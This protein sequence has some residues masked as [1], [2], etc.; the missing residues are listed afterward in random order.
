MEELQKAKNAKGGFQIQVSLVEKSLI[1]VPV[2]S[3]HGQ[4][5]SELASQ[6]CYKLPNGTG[7]LRGANETVT[8]KKI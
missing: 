8:M 6:S 7:P 1:F 2:A 3:R 5:N 4:G